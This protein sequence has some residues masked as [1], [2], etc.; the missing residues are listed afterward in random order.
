MPDATINSHPLVSIFTLDAE[1]TKDINP[2][3]RGQ[4]RLH[5]GFIKTI[6]R[7]IGCRSYDTRG[8]RTMGCNEMGTFR[9]SE[10]CWKVCTDVLADSTSFLTPIRIPVWTVPDA[11]A[12]LSTAR[13]ATTC[14]LLTIGDFTIHAVGLSA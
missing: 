6:S 12:A 11:F 7:C 3:K 4:E 14:I 2:K 9:F 5:G 13:F 10:F 8:N 1:L